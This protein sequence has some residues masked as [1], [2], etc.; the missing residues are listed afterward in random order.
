MGM[1]TSVGL[2]SIA[3]LPIVEFKLS[4]VS[5]SAETDRVA[6]LQ[7]EDFFKS[8]MDA[9]VIVRVLKTEQAS[10]DE[11]YTFNGDLQVSSVQVLETVYGDL[12]AD[13][14]NVAQYLNGGCVGDEKTHL[15]REQGVYL[16]PLYRSDDYYYVV[17]DLDALLEIDPYG[18][19]YS[20]ASFPELSRYDGLSYTYLTTAIT[21]LAQDEDFMLS[22]TP[23][24]QRMVNFSLVEVVITSKTENSHAGIHTLKA[25]VRQN[26][27]LHEIPADID[28]IQH[29]GQFDFELIEPGKNYLLFLAY[30]EGYYYIEAIHTAA[31]GSD[32]TIEG[33]NEQHNVFAI[34]DGYTVE[35]IKTLAQRVNNYIQKH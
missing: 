15:L 6:Y 31:I 18:T 2:V 28:L 26:M 22:A 13:T 5:E 30:D 4:Q 21:Q 10:S 16:L 19:V 35:Q 17:G 23:F 29:Q 32:Q 33:F 3:G 9:F 11:T 12:A 20:H 24:G 34:Y 1:Y 7:I 27:S 25:V 8:N 14:V